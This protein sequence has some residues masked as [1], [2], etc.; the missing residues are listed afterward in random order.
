MRTLPLDQQ[1][2][3]ELNSLLDGISDATNLVFVCNP[4]NPTGTEVQT[5]DL[6]NFCRSVPENVL[7]CVDE[8]YVEYSNAGKA[9]SMVSLVHEIPNL[10]VCR[11]FSKAY[12]LAGLRIGYA[13]SSEANID[14]LRRRHLGYE[15]SAGWLPLAAAKASLDDDKFLEMC[16]RQNDAGKSILYDAFDQ[17][18]VKYDRSSTNFVY[19]SQDRF[20]KDLVVKLR[21]RGVLI[22]KWSDMASHVR[23]SIGRPSDMQAFINIV[24]EFLT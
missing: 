1:N 20:D 4:N 9:G 18:G 7:I 14:A 12:G 13:V 17:W 22:T 5:E 19:T 8:A 2:R 10:I 11:T 23:I 3:F 16:I 21:D 24:E 6:K 15:M